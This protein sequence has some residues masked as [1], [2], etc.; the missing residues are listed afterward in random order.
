MTV[1]FHDKMLGALLG[2]AVGDAMG[3]PFEGYWS[4]DIPEQ[5]ILAEEF[6]IFEGFPQGQFTDDTQLTLA[7]AHG[8]LESRSIDPEFIASHIGRLWASAEVIGPGGA[9]MEAGDHY[10]KHRRWREC[11]AP[12]GRAG[13]GAAMRVAFL[14]LCSLRSPDKLYPVV[15][16]VC[17]LTHHDP[18]S[19]AGGMAIAS[20]VQLQELFPDL[21]PEEQLRCLAK[22]V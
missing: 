9:C 1:E 15:R 4:F 20:L 17:R 10:L 8:I 11:G 18:R 2:C 12:I 21:S 16:D 19:V 5:S 6:Q 7:T 22:E 3:A 13:N 14:G